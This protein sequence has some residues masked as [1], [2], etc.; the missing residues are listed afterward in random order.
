MAVKIV[1]RGIVLVLVSVLITVGFTLSQQRDIRA[2]SVHAALLTPV[3]EGK[4]FSLEIQT[5]EAATILL[6]YGDKTQGAQGSDLIFSFDTDLALNR[7]EIRAVDEANN[8]SIEVLRFEPIRLLTAHLEAPAAVMPGNPFSAALRWEGE[9]LAVKQIA[10]SFEDKALPVF[11]RATEG[12]A[13][14]SIPLGQAAGAGT[15]SY[16]ITDEYDRVVAGHADIV[17][18]EETAGVE[19][20]NLSAAT[21]SVVTSDNLQLE[22]D[23]VAAAY[24]SATQAGLQWREPFQMPIA[25]IETSGFG[26]PRRYIRGGNISYHR[27]ADIAAPLGT[28][29]YAS[30]AG[31]VKVAEF[32]PIKGGFVMIDH[33]GDIFSLYLHQSQLYVNAGEP[34][35]RG[36]LIGAVGSTGLSTGPH[37]HWE[38]RVRGE[39]SN[40]LAWV[41]KVLP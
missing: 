22:A 34:V 6:R 36:Q 16:S 32:L 13:L 29:V 30:N 28:P 11:A 19:E 37:L 7:I 33:G 25:G 31:I 27:G 35:E 26:D 40:P 18:L 8:E 1:F 15:L 23:T 9:Q 12:F 14:A 38:M 41:G 5:D 24:A 17:I 10:M 2:P 21:F 20:L 4:S 39:A 3:L